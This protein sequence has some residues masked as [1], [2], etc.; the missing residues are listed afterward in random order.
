M[1]CYCNV[2]VSDTRRP[3]D[4]QQKLKNI[5][6]R[7]IFISGLYTLCF[8][9]YYDTPHH[10]GQLRRGEERKI[11]ENNNTMT[12][13]M[14][15]FAA[16]TYMCE[17]CDYCFFERLHNCDARVCLSLPLAHWCCC[18]VLSHIHNYMMIF[19]VCRI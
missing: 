17:Y 3:R 12:C 10:T 5:K 18:N 16:R 11:C 15:V 6:V 4:S 19:K 9:E 2:R 7:E 8:R 13:L 1:P 14:K